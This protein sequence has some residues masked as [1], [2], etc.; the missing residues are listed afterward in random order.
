MT[1]ASTGSKRSFWQQ[2]DTLSQN[3]INN[4]VDVHRLAN[5]QACC[6]IA[7]L[8]KSG[9]Q[10]GK[11]VDVR[12]AVHGCVPLLTAPSLCRRTQVLM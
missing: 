1:V 6:V 8:L 10:D 11:A 12:V 3:S 7:C 2:V 9:E 4:P 5:S